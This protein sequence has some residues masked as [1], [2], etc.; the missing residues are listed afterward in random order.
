MEL[1]R[2][3]RVDVKNLNGEG[4][5]EMIILKNERVN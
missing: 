3:R 5:N 4:N 1:K 2:E